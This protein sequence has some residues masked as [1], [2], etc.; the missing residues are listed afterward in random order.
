MNDASIV[1]SYDSGS[2]M[3]IEGTRAFSTDNNP[4]TDTGTD[5]LETQ[6]DEVSMGELYFGNTSDGPVITGAGFDGTHAPD[7]LTGVKAISAGTMVP[8]DFTYKIP[9]KIEN[10]DGNVET[11]YLLLARNTENT[12]TLP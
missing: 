9:V 2:G 12:S 4:W 5:K 3:F 8:N 1:T 10:T 7:T 11:Y 6:A